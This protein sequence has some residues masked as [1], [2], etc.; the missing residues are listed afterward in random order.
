MKV[1][2][3]VAIGAAVAGLPGC[4]EQ[5]EKPGAAGPGPGGAPKG[6][7]PVPVLTAVAEQA[8]VPVELRALGNVEPIQ[9]SV[10]RSLITGTVTAVGFREGEM[11]R[12]GQ[13]LFRLDRRPLE[14][15]LRELP[16]LQDVTSDLLLKNPEL[17]VEIDRDRAS[18]LGVSVEQIE[19]TLYYAYGARQVST[20]YYTY[21]DGLQRRFKRLFGIGQAAA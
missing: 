12:A 2:L 4:G 8:D 17:N 5:A 19:N 11:V 3:L 16:G 13:V 1:L 20:I 10:V 18:A 7:P 15:T 6:R 14:A 9:S 21:F